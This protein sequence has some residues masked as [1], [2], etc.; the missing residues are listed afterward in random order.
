[1]DNTP[2]YIVKPLNLR[3]EGF[4]DYRW[5]YF[6]LE[7]ANLNPIFPDSSFLDSEPLIEDSPAHY[8]SAQYA[9]YGVYDY[10]S[11]VPLP[12]EAKSVLRCKKGPS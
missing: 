2:C 10:D 12:P 3:F 4:S 6:L 11:G 5:N 1:M 8:V 7:L 9:Q